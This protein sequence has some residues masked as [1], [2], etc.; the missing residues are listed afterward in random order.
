MIKAETEQMASMNDEYR[1]NK[2]TGKMLDPAGMKLLTR[3]YHAWPLTTKSRMSAEI[4]KAVARVQA[5][6]DAEIKRKV[7]AIENCESHITKLERKTHDL[8]QASLDRVQF[9]KEV[10]NFV[11]CNFEAKVFRPD[12]N[13]VYGIHTTFNARAFGFGCY[14]LSTMGILARECADQV[15]ACILKSKFV[16][17]AGG[18]GG[19][20]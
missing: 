5:K 16:K 18:I 7:A 1:G 13:G 6:H 2:S 3:L 8:I 14:S 15:A 17:P 12:V 4:I 19:P 20:S 11:A 9:K 10:E